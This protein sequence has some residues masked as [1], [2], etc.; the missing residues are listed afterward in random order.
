MSWGWLKELRSLRHYLECHHGKPRHVG[1]ARVTLPADTSTASA[2]QRLLSE[3]GVSLKP[4]LPHHQEGDR[5][6]IHLG[7]GETFQ[8]VMQ[9]FDPPN[10]FCARVENLQ[11]SFLRAWVWVDKLHG[12]GEA[13]IQI[14]TYGLPKEVSADFEKR[15][16]GLLQRLF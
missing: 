8:A 11:Q 2:W 16:N 1:W 13:N 7:A 14:S 4:A 12:F 9:Y 3:N 6:E 5:C 10:F 15:W